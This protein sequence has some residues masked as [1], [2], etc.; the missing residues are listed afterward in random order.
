MSGLQWSDMWEREMDGDEKLLCRLISVDPYDV[1]YI[2][3]LR[4][5]LALLLVIRGA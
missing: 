2:I 5:L 4:Y 1:S 3:P